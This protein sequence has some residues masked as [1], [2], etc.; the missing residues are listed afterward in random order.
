MRRKA[1]QVGFVVAL[2]LQQITSAPAGAQAQ[3]PV[4]TRGTQILPLRDRPPV[5]RVGTGVLKGRV[6]DGTT[7]ASVPRA[8]VT[9]QGVA[10][11][12][13]PVTTDGSGVFA[14]ANLPPGPVTVMVEKSTF[15]QARYPESGRTFRSAGRGLVLG[16][17]QVLDDVTVR[18]FHGCAIS[19]RVLDSNGDPV[20]FAQVNAVRA[21]APG[22]SGRPVQRSSSSSNDL[23][24]FRVGRL[25]PGTY[26][27]QVIPRRMSMDQYRSDAAPAAPPAPAAAQPLPTYYPSAIAL[28]QAQPITLERGQSVSDLDVVLAEGLPAVIAGTV[29]GLDGQPVSGNGYVNARAVAREG[30]GGF[31]GSGTGIRPDGTFRMTLPPGEWVIEARLNPPPGTM[32]QRQQDEQLGSVRISVVGGA[33][34][35]VSIA[36]GRGATATGRVVFEGSSPPPSSPAGQVHVPMYSQDGACR[37]GTATVAADWTFRLEGLFGQCSVQPMALFGRWTVKAVMHNGDNL[38]DAPHTF[39][40]GQQLRNV[41]VIVTD[42]RSDVTFRVADDNGQT[43][44]EYV[45]LLY[46]VD[47]TQWSQAVRTMTGPPAEL[48]GVPS[49]APVLSG[50]AR[51][52]MMAP[53]MRRESMMAVKP[54]EYYAVA[55]DDMEMEDS[56]DPLVLERL[57]SS[58]VRVMVSEGASQEI[59]LRRVKMADVMR[60]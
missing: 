21:P 53:A 44:R 12:R 28:D 34:E 45:A 52:P 3:Q 22:R 56:R 40:P 54:G 35:T 17:G 1:R 25:E 24:E 43:T 8:R 7:G 38:L 18:I 13:P 10:S 33:E 5:V 20:E 37:S 4:V 57:A 19:G 27:L 11:G 6:V 23:G 58:G 15:L 49:R 31:D 59:A 46:P 16:D 14:F 50:P 55:V 2:L 51:T 47:K 36:V 41:Q 26:V 9:L 60:K 30:I 32:Q 48:M 42:K 29:T 39:Q